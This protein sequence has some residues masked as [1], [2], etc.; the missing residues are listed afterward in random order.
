M[1]FVHGYNY[2][3]VPLGKFKLYIYLFYFDYMYVESADI[4]LKGMDLGILWAYVVEENGLPEENWSWISLS[5]TTLP[6]AD[7]SGFIPG[8]SRNILFPSLNV[9]LLQSQWWCVL[10]AHLCN[11]KC[12]HCSIFKWI[13]LT[14]TCQE[15][16]I[17]IIVPPWTGLSK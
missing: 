13:C 5:S 14:W 17:F 12:T 3:T 10:A 1:F 9:S 6:H 2:K 11:A 4:E 16:P 15:G 7:T 8:L